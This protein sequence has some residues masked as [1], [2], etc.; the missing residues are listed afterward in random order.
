MGCVSVCGRSPEVLS[1]LPL[2]NS[3]ASPFEPFQ[4]RGVAWV[5][6]R[7]AEFG[8]KPHPQVTA[9]D[10]TSAQPALSGG[11]VQRTRLHSFLPTLMDL[12]SANPTALLTL[13]SLSSPSK[14]SNVGVLVAQTHTHRENKNGLRRPVRLMQLPCLALPCTCYLLM[15]QLGPERLSNSAQGAQLALGLELCHG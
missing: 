3:L 7:A 12:W 15:E 13:H 9:G 6:T 4:R 1:D 5:S 8:Q 10:G 2:R 11:G 14:T